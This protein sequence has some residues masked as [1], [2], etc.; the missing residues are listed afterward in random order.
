M[1][2]RESQ[3]RR[4]ADARISALQASVAARLACAFALAGSRPLGQ[5]SLP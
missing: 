1:I 3:R 5:I 4:S 2:W